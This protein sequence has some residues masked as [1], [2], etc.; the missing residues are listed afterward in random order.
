[1]VLFQYIYEVL[2]EIDET[3][4]FSK[5]NWLLLV[6]TILETIAAIILVGTIKYGKGT[7]KVRHFLTSCNRIS[8]I[9]LPAA[10]DLL[11]PE[12]H[13]TDISFPKLV[14]T[15]TVRKD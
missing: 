7:G 15:T 1:M 2:H 10:N 9:P 8:K 5:P 11:N 4:P 13:T 14:S 6:I 3:Y 12:K